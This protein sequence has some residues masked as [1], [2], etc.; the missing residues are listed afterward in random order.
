MSFNIGDIVEFRY[1]EWC[2]QYPDSQYPGSIR[3]ASSPQGRARGEVTKVLPGMRQVW[4]RW[5]SGEISL[6]N[7][8]WV[9]RISP[10]VQLAEATN[11]NP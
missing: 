2:S 4:V 3:R 7:I 8:R 10:L 5:S 11:E 1:D 9:K 6:F